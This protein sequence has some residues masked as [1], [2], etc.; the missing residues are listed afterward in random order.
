MA[1]RRAQSN[2]SSEFAAKLEIVQLLWEYGA[3]MNLKGG[4]RKETPLAVAVDSLM[5]DLVDFMLKNGSNPNSFDRDQRTPL[6][7][8][9]SIVVPSDDGTVA[10]SS[11]AIARLLLLRGANFH[12]R[13]ARSR[14]PLIEAVCHRNEDLVLLLLEFG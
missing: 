3:K 2:S 13:D 7:V 4:S 1:C 10:D 6:H 11:Q 14:T 8:A 12:A 5:V 9:C